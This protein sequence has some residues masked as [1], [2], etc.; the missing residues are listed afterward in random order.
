[1]V[2]KRSE[3]IERLKAGAIMHRRAMRTWESDRYWLT[4]GD[5]GVYTLRTTTGF[6]LTQQYE[7]VYDRRAGHWEWR[8]N[9]A[10]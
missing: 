4:Q 3:A 1:M 6:W 7:L 10:G 9:N 2:I 5:L 8:A